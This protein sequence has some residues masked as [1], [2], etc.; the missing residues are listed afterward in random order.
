MNG[1]K[2]FQGLK[3]TMLPQTFQLL[4]YCYVLVQG[5]LTSESNHLSSSSVDV[6]DCTASHQLSIIVGMP[7]FNAT[8]IKGAVNTKPACLTQQAAN[9]PSNKELELANIWADIMIPVK[10]QDRFISLLW[11][12]TL[13]FLTLRMCLKKSNKIPVK[14]VGRNVY[15]YIVIRKSGGVFSLFSWLSEGP[16]G[17][18]GCARSS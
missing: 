14:Q 12:I 17:S 3:V 16:A 9:S 15:F 4:K 13:H 1:N 2:C 6:G 8:H 18:T 7:S 5:P 11:W 10:F